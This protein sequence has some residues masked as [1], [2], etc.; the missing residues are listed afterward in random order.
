MNS[1]AEN[2]YDWATVTRRNRLKN[3]IMHRSN[4]KSERVYSSN[5][6][7]EKK[8]DLCVRVSMKRIISLLVKT[9]EFEA[10]RTDIV[11][12][13]IDFFSEHMIKQ[14]EDITRV[15]FGSKTLDIKGVIIRRSVS[16]NKNA[17]REM[18]MFEL[19]KHL[20]LMNQ[21]NDP[22]D[23]ITDIAPH[24]T[25]IKDKLNNEGCGP[26]HCLF[27]SVAKMNNIVST[28]SEKW[29]LKVLQLFVSLGCHY[30]ETNKFGE[31][32]NISYHNAI[33]NGF[34]KYFADV[35]YFLKHGTVPYKNVKNIDPDE[36]RKQ[37]VSFCGKI[38]GTMNTAKFG[39]LAD[40]LKM[41]LAT[42]RQVLPRDEQFPLVLLKSGIFLGLNGFPD[43]NGFYEFPVKMLECIKQMLSVPLSK[44]S[45]YNTI[46]KNIN[47]PTYNEMLDDIFL[48]T[49]EHKIDPLRER[50][51]P[52]IGALVTEITVYNK[53]PE[54][55][56][57][58]MHSILDSFEDDSDNTIQ[59]TL[60]SIAFGHL[61]R[62]ENNIFAEYMTT[63]ICR[64]I[65]NLV[66]MKK[67]VRVSKSRMQNAFE[68]IAKTSDLGMLETFRKSIYKTTRQTSEVSNNIANIQSKKKKGL[69][70]KKKIKKISNEEKKIRAILVDTRVEDL[71]CEL[72]GDYRIPVDYVVDDENGETTNYWQ[73]CLLAHMKQYPDRWLSIFVTLCYQL[74][75]DTV[76]KLSDD[77]MMEVMIQFKKQIIDVFVKSGVVNEI[78]IKET[79]RYLFDQFLDENGTINE[80]ID[81]EKDDI[82]IE[83]EL[84]SAWDNAK[85]LKKLCQ[86]FATC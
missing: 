18:L 34:C 33:K 24:L 78:L 65:A 72:E 69:M 55:F 27:W 37:M 32:A 47:I 79:I 50:G 6:N 54:K 71:I 39:N 61:I 83:H 3:P 67:I 43:P 49:I 84:V 42:S 81:W 46:L 14:G 66:K 22:T 52:V 12:N 58:W 63:D 80:D 23:Y 56:N 7:G 30:N 20:P 11:D 75:N 44:T 76:A 8:R 59:Q 38:S 15:D 5:H 85:R 51:Y 31:N 53:H 26:I 19:I 41:I 74:T 13:L 45:P 86:I 36:L 73:E 17:I 9:Y 77:D 4:P 28:L 2:G 57:S 68:K 60:V 62:Y 1:F 35:D 21:D 10:I 48:H 40:M 64:K 70:K 16:E 29:L 25:T 82:S